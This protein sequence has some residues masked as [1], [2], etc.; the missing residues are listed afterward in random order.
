M[1]TCQIT[2]ETNE[3]KKKKIKITHRNQIEQYVDNEITRY[4]KYRLIE[5]IFRRRKKKKN[6]DLFAETRDYRVYNVCTLTYEIFSITEKISMGD[7]V[8]RAI[9]MREFRL[10]KLIASVTV[11][12]TGFPLIVTTRVYSRHPQKNSW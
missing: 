10:P 8:R 12:R 6:L 9:Q 1:F 4:L 3:T 11:R 2:N 7:I 5:T